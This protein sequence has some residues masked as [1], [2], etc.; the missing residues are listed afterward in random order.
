VM[1]SRGIEHTIVN[2]EVIY[3]DNALQASSA[4]QLIR[5]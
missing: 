3:A 1:P 5:S 4:G 2:G